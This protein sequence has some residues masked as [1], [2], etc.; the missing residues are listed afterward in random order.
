MGLMPQPVSSAVDRIV[1]GNAIETSIL[2]NPDYQR[3]RKLLPEQLTSMKY[4]DTKRGLA[5]LYRLLLAGVMVG[6][7]LAPA[8]DADIDASQFP[9]FQTFTGN[10]YGDVSGA[11]VDDTGY[12]QAG[13]GPWPF[14]VPSMAV[15][16]G[17]TT[18]VLVSILL[19]SLSRARELS[20]RLVSASNL[21]G[22]GT[23]CLIYAYD[24]N[25]QFPPNLQTLIDSG[26]ILEKRLYD[27]NGDSSVWSYKYITG[28]GDN[29]APRWVVAYESYPGQ[30]E[31]GGNV[32]FADG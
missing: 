31:E 27:P 25:G 7:N 22:L 6:G 5:G 18:A 2:A 4:N 23:A 1:A 10:L 24:H 8:L 32:L 26:D 16:G 9:N 20:K 19:P 17:A 30:T 12:H 3:G 28:H 15:G 14:P 21:K 11:W 29:S 13:H